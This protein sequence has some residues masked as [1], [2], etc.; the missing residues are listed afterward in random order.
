LASTK[1]RATDADYAV[2]V[3]QYEAV[4]EVLKRHPLG[5]NLQD[6]A[7]LCALKVIAITWAQVREVAPEL[8]A[9]PHRGR[10]GGPDDGGFYDDPRP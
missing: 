4:L 3:P 1:A 6:T 8:A 9:A 10:G 7:A 2:L 5:G